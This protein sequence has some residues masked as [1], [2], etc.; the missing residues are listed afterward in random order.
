MI[1][2]LPTLSRDS[3]KIQ[4]LFT[5]LQSQEQAYPEK[6]WLGLLQKLKR[7][8]IEDLYQA[9]N[10]YVLFIPILV[11]TGIGIYYALPSEPSIHTVVYALILGVIIIAKVKNTPPYAIT[12][13]LCALFICLIGFSAAKFRTHIIN[14][15]QLSKDIRYAEIHGNI[16]LVERLSQND[17]VRLTL[18]KVEF[19]EEKFSEIL[20][21]NI[22]VRVRKAKFSDFRT[23]QRVKGLVSLKPPS[24][25]VAHG[26]FNFK[27]Q[28]YFKGLS[29]VGFFFHP[30]QIIT[31]SE[32]PKLTQTINAT[33]DN[34]NLKILKNEHL[35]K[36]A[37]GVMSALITGIRTAIPYELQDDIRAAGLAHLLAISGLHVG[38]VTAA[39]FFCLRLLI[40]LIPNISLKYSTKKWAAVGSLLLAAIY[41]LI[42]GTGVPALRAFLTSTLIVLAIAI[43]RNPFSLRL[44]AIVA[45]VILLIS[46]EVL[47]GASF[48]MSF[49]AVVGLIAFYEWT[50]P[51]W[52]KF[53][54]NNTTTNK[55]ITYVLALCC[56]SIIATIATAPIS[57]FHFQHLAI[58]SLFTNLI[59]VPVMGIIVMP[60]LMLSLLLMPFGLESLTLPIANWGTVLI[61]EV[62]KYSAD[63][64]MAHLQIPAINLT[65]YISIILTSICIIFPPRILKIAAL[66]PAII[67][68]AAINTNTTTIGFIS[69]SGEQFLICPTTQQCYSKNK[70]TERFT[71]KK[72][73]EL[74]ALPYDKIAP[75]PKGEKKGG[76]TC[77]EYAC[78]TTIK[79]NKISI[80]MDEHAIKEECLWADHIWSSVP[81]YKRKCNSRTII[82]RFDLWENGTYTIFQ[83]NEE[84]DIKNTKEYIKNRPW[85]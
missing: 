17:G 51:F 37:A 46:P 68:L 56:T 43:D 25:P 4:V 26:A 10:S 73:S 2:S 50:K 72:W 14:T 67:T 47:L 75:V 19:Q 23:G 49:A 24:A 40:S 1:V 59:A 45:S 7:L 82:N 80:I 18:N 61:I 65:N 21:K 31:D 3:G 12:A 16:K 35:N 54:K 84:I 34:I 27:R 33:R 64:H 32:Q 85:S 79:D 83:T 42:A 71:L 6:K 52:I 77:D 74:I 62:A 28:A 58:Y 29:A 57:I 36:E 15:P 66:I 8:A 9:I 63:I 22:R 81:I 55:I 13:T 69:G 20:V 76:I 70:F 30:P 38:M 44:V 48:Q 11:A 60:F 5:T 53:Y 39:A 78:R 41:V